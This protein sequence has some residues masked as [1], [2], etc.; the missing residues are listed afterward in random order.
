MRLVAKVGTYRFAYRHEDGE[1]DEESTPSG[2]CNLKEYGRPQAAC[3]RR[4][5]VAG[6]GECLPC[7]GSST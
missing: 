5:S 3:L 1:R 7:L 2:Y 4:S 6:P